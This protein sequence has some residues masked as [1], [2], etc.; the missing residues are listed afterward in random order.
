M[1]KVEIMSADSGGK[2]KE[3]HERANGPWDRWELDDAARHLRRAHDISGNKKFLEAIKKH[4][5]EEAEEH[6]ETARHAEMLAKH[7]KISEKALAK[8]KSRKS[9]G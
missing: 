2:Y 3:P 6:H 9:H 1:P 5:E 4:Q 8:A 7:G